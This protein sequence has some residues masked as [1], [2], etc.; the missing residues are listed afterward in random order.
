MIEGA[1]LKY[2]REK[3]K[4]TIKELSKK[5]HVSK[6]IIEKWENDE[7][8]PRSKDIE[9]ICE[10][11]NITK[12][13][14]IIEEKSKGKIIISIVLF[15]C[16]IIVGRIVNDLAITIILPIIL[17]TILNISLVIKSNY[18]L[19]KKNHGPKSLFGIKLEQ[20]NK[21]SRYKYYLLESIVLSSS[22]ILITIACKILD[23]TRFIITIEF[24]ANASVNFLIIWVSTFILLTIASFLIEF[25]FG[26]F[27][28]RRYVNIMED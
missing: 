7:L 5:I 22:Y 19:S 2:Y 15:I 16:G 17:V 9:I 12:D 10:L 4:L 11:Y 18:Q 6:N 25:I 13:D 23:F 27:M 3:E 21:T 28:V 26:E 24:T 1:L 14:L 8:E 20:S